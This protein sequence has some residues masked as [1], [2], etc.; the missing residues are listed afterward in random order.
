[1]LFILG[2]PS[3]I[4]SPASIPSGNHP[5]SHFHKPSCLKAGITCPFPKQN[6]S[7][8][9]PKPGEHLMQHHHSVIT[10]S[11]KLSP[12]ANVP[13]LI[14]FP[15]P[16]QKPFWSD[17]G[18]QFLET[19]APG[20]QRPQFNLPGKTLMPRASVSLHHFPVVSKPFRSHIPPFCLKDA[21]PPACAQ[22]SITSQEHQLPSGCQ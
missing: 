22:V 10:I 15:T 4:T 1:M 20:L 13:T 17:F 19:W 21:S 3:S 16:H 11:Q 2:V 12:I 7:P 14:Y 8:S 9:L 18:A 5:L 6:T